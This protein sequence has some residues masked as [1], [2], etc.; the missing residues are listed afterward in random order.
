MLA[1]DFDSDSIGDD[2]RPVSAL[3]AGDRLPGGPRAWERLG[4]GHRCETW[5]GW[6]AHLCAPVVVKF[7]R[8]DQIGE[9]RAARALAREVSALRDN[10]H[11]ALPRLYRDG[12]D[13]AFAFLELE[14]VDGTALDEDIEQHGRFAPVELALLMV[15]LL[16]GL[17]AV[18]ARGLV[19]VDVK[20]DNVMIREGR[21]VLVDFGSARPIGS[22]Q[23]TGT[24]IGSPGYAAPELEAGAP[25]S[26]A[27]D[28]YGV[29]TILYEALC[30]APA[31]EPDVPAA[32]RTTPD[33]LDDND[34]AHL[35]LQ[36]LDPDP[37]CRPD[38]DGAVHELARTCAAGGMA[39]RPDWA[40]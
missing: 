28:L 27:M 34:T 6:S 15:Q 8:P 37:S 20:P 38:L 39:F 18:H 1:L 9:P 11:P 36:L 26:P 14:Y 5:L 40:R 25:L 17:R 21:P 23:P 19:H 4:V 33:P 13:D 29:G 35:A 12:S 7:P 31:F 10:L 3:S 16:A 2:G 30:G 24:L 32:E 22:R